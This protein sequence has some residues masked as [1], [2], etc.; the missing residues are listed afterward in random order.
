MIIA[1][2]GSFLRQKVA[3]EAFGLLDDFFFVHKPLDY[4]A[5]DDGD[6]RWEEAKNSF[7]KEQFLFWFSS[8]TIKS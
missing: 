7:G 4:R 5:K 8:F 2:A 6:D 1:V 3:N